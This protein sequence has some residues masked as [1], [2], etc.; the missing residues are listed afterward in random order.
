[1]GWDGRGGVGWTGQPGEDRRDKP[2]TLRGRGGDRTRQQ[3]WPSPAAKPRRS[4]SRCV[5]SA[6]T[7]LAARQAGHAVGVASGDPR[8]HAWAHSS[9]GT[10][11]SILQ[12][13]VISS[14]VCSGNGPGGRTAGKR[15]VWGPAGT[16][17]AGHGLGDT[18]TGCHH[19]PHGH[20][21]PVVQGWGHLRRA[22]MSTRTHGRASVWMYRH[23]DALTHGP[24]G[25]MDTRTPGHP[26]AHTGTRPWG[27]GD[28]GT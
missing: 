18:A 27:H 22:G 25:N 13:H 4:H 26:G 9:A 23:R 17:R 5:G 19:L 3:G 10:F 7:V 6:A 28:S 21:L 15:Q 20:I 11:P 24:T 14:V 8:A 12:S 16:S 2:G 1:M